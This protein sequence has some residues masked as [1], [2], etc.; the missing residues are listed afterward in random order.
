MRRHKFYFFDV[1]VFQE[2]KSAY[3]SKLSSDTL[4]IA[5]ESLVLQEIRAQNE[6]KELDY[7]IYDWRTHEG[8]EVDFILYGARGFKAI[9]VKYKE[10]LTAKDFSGLKYFQEEYPECELFMIYLGKTSYRKDDVR[11]MNAQKFLCSMTDFI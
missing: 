3:T 11:V 5:L 10:N 4:G 7:N 1:G 6:Y 9:E 2:L 8:K